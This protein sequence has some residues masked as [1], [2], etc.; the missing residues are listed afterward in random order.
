VLVEPRILGART[1]LPK[2]GLDLGPELSRGVPEQVVD[3]I[4]VDQVPPQQ[5]SDLVVEVPD[6]RGDLSPIS[7]KDSWNS[8]LSQVEYSLVTR[9]VLLILAWFRIMR[10]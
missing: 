9:S 1:R 3:E 2:D 6:V 5:R 7:W 8:R 4:E 10:L